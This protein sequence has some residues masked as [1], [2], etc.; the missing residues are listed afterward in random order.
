MSH[1]ITFPIVI[2]VIASL[3]L[4]ACTTPAPA[5]DYM[6]VSPAEAYSRTEGSAI[7]APA[8]AANITGSSYTTDSA[9]PPAGERIVIRNADIALIVVDPAQSMD[10]IA[11]MSEEMGGFVVASQLYQRYVD[12]TTEVP[13][14]SLT[15]R[16]PAARLNEAMERIQNESNRPPVRRNVN[17]QDVTSTYVDLTSRKRN[18]EA[19]ETQLQGIMETAS[20][21][22]D[23]L[24]IYNELVRVREQIEVIQGQL[25]YYEQASAL[26]SIAITLTPD[27]A[28]Q[29]LTIAGWEPGGVA[30]SAIQALINTVQG[31]V[32]VGI[33]VF[34]YFVP[35]L[36]L[37]ALPLIAATLVVRR[38]RKGSIPPAAAAR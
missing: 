28:V 25:N 13:E 8:L 4:V 24:R 21:T 20:S 5:A 38:L 32:N 31:L 10:R 27:V 35:V 23:V 37:L 14:G 26:S 15:V 29:P 3:L 6:K 22:D 34:L 11:R 9:N 33:W 16:V 1:K 18:L 2:L 7:Q 17:S 12:A 30:K 36:L 19:A